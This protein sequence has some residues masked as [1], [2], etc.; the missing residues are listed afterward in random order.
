MLQL[1]F[2]LSAL[3]HGDD[4]SF[5]PGVLARLQ[6]QAIQSEVKKLLTDASTY[7]PVHVQPWAHFVANS[8]NTPF[9]QPEVHAHIR[10]VTHESPNDPRGWYEAT[11]E[12]RVPTYFWRDA[13]GNSSGY[14]LFPENIFPVLQQSSQASLGDRGIVFGRLSEHVRLVTLPDTE[15]SPSVKLLLDA[16]KKV[17]STESEATYFVFY[18]V[19]VGEH[20]LYVTVDD[21]EG[22]IDVPVAAGTVTFLDVTD[23]SFR[24]LRGQVFS[25]PELAHSVPLDRVTVRVLGQSEAVAETD[26]DGF[27]EIE[28]VIAFGSYPLVME[29]DRARGYTHRYKVGP[30]DT[31]ELLRIPVRYINHWLKQSPEKIEGKGIIYGKLAPGQQARMRQAKVEHLRPVDLQVGLGEL[32]EAQDDIADASPFLGIA[33]PEGLT[34]VGIVANSHVQLSTFFPV[35]PGV[36]DVMPGI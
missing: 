6:F 32:L 1:L 15:E 34:K 28:G 29:T 14:E 27:F 9:E 30:D 21:Q 16:D 17:V 23:I 20:L 10:Q 26:Q 11:A 22:A 7:G 13:Q 5:I 36:I 25:G 24:S 2:L 19:A 33:S 31:I 3:A 12:G 8:Q 35:S 4:I 18:G